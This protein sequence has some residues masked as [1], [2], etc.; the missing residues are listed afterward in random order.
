MSTERT[1]D[2]NR[3]LIFDT[4]LRDGEQAPGFSLGVEHK[5][6]MAHALKDLGVDIIEAG[7]A[8]SSPGDE[9]AIQTIAREVHGPTFASLCRAL[10]SDIDAATRALA[11]AKNRRCHVFLATSPIHREFKL[12]KSRSQVVEITAKAIAHAKKSFDDIEFSAEDAIRTEPDFLAEVCIAAAEAGATTLNLPDTVG[13]TTPKEIFKIFADVKAALKDHPD[14]IL[15]AHNHNDLGLAVA[16][17][18]AALEA[19]AR[20]IELTI[21]GIGERAGNAALE[22]VVMALRTRPDVYGL[23][24]G[25]DTTKLAHTSRLLSRATGTVVVRNKAVVGK[26]AFA[27]ESGIHQHGMLSNARTYEI[28]NPEDVGIEKSNLVLGKHSG[29]HA[30]AK[31]A[32][33]LGYELDELALGELFTAFKRRADEIGEIDE[34][35]LMSLLT[36][37]N[38]DKDD[39]RLFKITSETTRDSVSITLDLFRDNGDPLQVTASGLNAFEAGFRALVDAYQIE[40]RVNDCEIIQSGFTFDGGAFAEISLQIKGEVYRGR[41]R[42]PD[43]V[44]AGLRAICDGFEKYVFLHDRKMKAQNS[45]SGKI[46]ETAR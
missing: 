42:G 6:M 34:F 37:S 35:E 13:Y 33:A 14:I 29:R 43:P 26:N 12:K 44:W 45:D 3:V 5:L 27:H 9:E 38:A 24:T 19:G 30:I 15:S 11:P 21:N 41:G 10:E 1:K 20:Q 17:T 4:S 7:F 16:N 31:Q 18:L 46:H 2:P 28:M 8:A 23:H 40:A 25:I 36:R 32:A 22:E 39:A